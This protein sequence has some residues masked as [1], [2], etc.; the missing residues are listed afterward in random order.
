ME[1]QEGKIIYPIAHRR[2]CSNSGPVKA[3]PA[4]S[5]GDPDVFARWSK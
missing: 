1:A 2:Q 5:P 4:L 3:G